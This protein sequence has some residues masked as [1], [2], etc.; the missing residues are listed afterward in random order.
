MIK[1]ILTP[2]LLTAGIFSAF[3]LQAQSQGG[4][5]AGATVS[6]YS[7]FEE[8]GYGLELGTRVPHSTGYSFLGLEG[9]YVD[10]SE[11]VE[12]FN[13]DVE[14][15]GL[16]AAYRFHFQPVPRNKAFNLYVGGSAGVARGEV[17]VSGFGSESDT[18]FAWSLV[19]G[20][21][22]ALT[23]TVALR[24]GYR[25]LRLEDIFDESGDEDVFEVSVNVRF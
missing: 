8:I 1:R 5:Q 22:F 19:A 10:G 11:R 18:G 21:E 15:A 6:Y 3:A 13:V 14:L 4:S 23:R 7:D 12:G 20:A 9:S 16:F 2:L 25:L 17:R 24:G